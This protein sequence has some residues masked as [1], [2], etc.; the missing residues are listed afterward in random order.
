MWPS[1]NGTIRNILNGTVFREPIICKNI[2]RIIPNWIKNNAKWWSAGQIGNKDF[3]TGSEYMIR[4]EIIQV[5]ASSGQKSEEAVI[6]DWIRNNAGWWSADQIGDK[7][8]L[9]GIEYLVK[10]GII[11]VGH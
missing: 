7:D 11:N 5:S 2:P 4:E 9:A 8:F 6:P 1:P 3:V 10:S